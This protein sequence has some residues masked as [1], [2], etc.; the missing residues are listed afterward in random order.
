MGGNQY[1][2]EIQRN[3]NISFKEAE[4]TKLGKASDS[5][6]DDELCQV[7]DGVSTNLSLE[8]KRSIDFFLGANPAI[9]VSKIFICGGGARTARL[10][11]IMQESTALAVE[12]ANPLN[13]IAC[14]TD[15][16][17]PGFIEEM[18]PYFGVAVGLATRSLGDR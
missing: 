12:I 14:N 9:I 4:D 1:A 6:P 15:D 18:A 11:D 2:E 17:E 10:S 3:F 7:V 16:F 5:A 8:V 13:G